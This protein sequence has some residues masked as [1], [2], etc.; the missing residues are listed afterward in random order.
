MWTP[1][2]QRKE[3]RPTGTLIFLWVLFLLPIGSCGGI[4]ASKLLAARQPVL[5]VAAPAKLMSKSDV[6]LG[7]Y[8]DT[9]LDLE[10]VAR[11]EF[12][13]AEGY[14]LVAEGYS[15]YA[16]K[17]VPDLIVLSSE[18]LASGRIEGQICE[19]DAKL[20]CELPKKEL[21]TY[22]RAR[23]RTQKTPLRVL[24]AHAKPGD[25]AGEAWIG[26]GVAGVVLLLALLSTFQ[27]LR[28]ARRSGPV[29]LSRTLSLRHTPEQIRA[30]IRAQSGPLCRIAHD[31]ADRLVL[32][33]GKPAGSA[34]LTGAREP[35]DIP[36]RV[37]LELGAADAY[38]GTPATLRIQELLNRPPQALANVLAEGPTRIAG[39]RAAAWIIAV[40]DSA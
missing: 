29:G 3:A 30:K 12:P 36:L 14:A 1:D 6:K 19:A 26:L 38:R 39:E 21:D 13:T 17:G 4:G 31:A 37:D 11:D 15:A 23:Q 2:L 18:A 35:Q 5:H 8:V 25:T 20:A 7:A 16:V 28:V 10:L 24:V 32:L 22:V 40:C 33:V 27:L 34:R 9:N